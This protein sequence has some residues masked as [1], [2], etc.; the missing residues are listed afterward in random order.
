MRVVTVVTQMATA[1]KYCHEQSVLHGALKSRNVFLVLTDSGDRVKSV[2][3]RRG[4]MFFN[5]ILLLF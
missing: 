3:V 1:L 2:K 5:I 4:A